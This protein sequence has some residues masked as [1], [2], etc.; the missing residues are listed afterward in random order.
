VFCH[1]LALYNARASRP[2]RLLLHNE[3]F[4]AALCFAKL[5]KKACSTIARAVRSNEPFAT[6]HLRTDIEILCTENLGRIFILTMVDG[7]RKP[8]SG[9]PEIRNKGGRAI[10][11]AGP[12][13]K[14]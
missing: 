1:S 9:R 10:S 14:K 3:T 11:K 4:I 5:N 12:I 13:G 6:V 2:I 8:N 7:N